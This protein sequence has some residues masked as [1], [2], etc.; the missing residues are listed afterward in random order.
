MVRDELHALCV[1]LAAAFGAGGRAG[2]RLAAQRL[3]GAASE[4]ARPRPARADLGATLRTACEAQDA[5][6]A[7]RLVAA[8]ADVLPW[9]LWKG[10]GLSPDVSSRLFTAE[11]LGPDG[12]LP[13]ADVRVGCLLSE[14]HTH[15]RLSCHAGEETYFVM[16]GTATW[17]MEG[18]EDARHPPGALVHHR[19]WVRHGRGTGPQPFLGAWRWSGDLDLTAFEVAR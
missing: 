9:Q 3:L 8:L 18:A 4:T 19:A 2:G 13:A 6:P 7:A 1:A 11:I 14:A 17:F 12:L 16:S 15:Y 5:V 10:E